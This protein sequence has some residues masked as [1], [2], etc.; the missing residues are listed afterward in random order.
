MARAKDLTKADKYYLDTH[1]NNDEID[2]PELAESVNNTQDVVKTYIEER[3]GVLKRTINT[4]VITKTS[5]GRSG[6]AVMTENASQISD[7][8]KKLTINTNKSL[9]PSMIHNCK[10]KD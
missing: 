2:L 6:I 1:L 4:Q 5:S 3:R 9:D 8:V 10:P 7:D